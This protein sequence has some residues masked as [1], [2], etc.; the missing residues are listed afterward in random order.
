M[1][2]HTALIHAWLLVGS[3]GE[4]QRNEAQASDYQ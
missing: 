4:H 3:F 1:M 2:T